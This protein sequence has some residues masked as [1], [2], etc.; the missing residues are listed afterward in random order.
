MSELEPAEANLRTY[1]QVLLR[2]SHWVIAV[3]VLSVAVAVAIGSIQRKEY[4]ASAQLLVTPTVTVP[5]SSTPQTITPADILTQLQLLTS[6]PVKER[7]ASRLGMKP[8]I[9]GSQIGQTNVISVIAM[10][11]TPSLAAQTADQCH[12]FI[13]QG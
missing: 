10:A 11:E 5:I 1:L 7:A 2:R 4:S 13:D 6:A 9:T 3:T 8:L 12:Q